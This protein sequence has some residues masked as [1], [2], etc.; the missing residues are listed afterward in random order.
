MTPAARLSFRDLK[1]LRGNLG[2]KPSTGEGQAER[3]K[4]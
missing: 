3:L 1:T 2:A 4:S